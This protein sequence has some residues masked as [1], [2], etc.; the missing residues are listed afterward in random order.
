M[1]PSDSHTHAQLSLT[2]CSADKPYSVV[3]DV[4]KALYTA[5]EIFEISL[6]KWRSRDN[7]INCCQCQ[8]MMPVDLFS[9]DSLFKCRVQKTKTGGPYWKEFSFQVTYF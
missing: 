6:N 2:A 9:L 4:E 5:E 7:N 8:E 3:E 1:A